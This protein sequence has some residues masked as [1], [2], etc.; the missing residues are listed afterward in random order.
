MAVTNL[1][2]AHDFLTRTQSKGE[3]AASNGT[4]I[5]AMEI[6]GVVCEAKEAA[7]HIAILWWSLRAAKLLRC[8]G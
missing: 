8:L 2:F 5:T 7:I 6:S 4:V 1:R 3:L